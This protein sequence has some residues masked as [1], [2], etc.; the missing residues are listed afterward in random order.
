MHTGT[1]IK[2]A[3]GTGRCFMSN[4]SR[5]KKNGTA[6]DPIVFTSMADDIT[7]GLSTGTNLESQIMDYGEVF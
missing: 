4:S 3:A 1:V 5:Q 2:E 6:S 7:D